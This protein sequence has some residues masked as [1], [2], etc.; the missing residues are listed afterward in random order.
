MVRQ[1][2]DRPSA[3]IAGAVVIDEN[4]PAVHDLREKWFKAAHR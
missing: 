3:A 4:K 1:I 2:M